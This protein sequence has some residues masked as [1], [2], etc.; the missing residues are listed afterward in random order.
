MEK[1]FGQ[2]FS[3]K[4]NEHLKRRRRL[5]VA[6]RGRT[7]NCWLAHSNA[8]TSLPL[9]F[10]TLLFEKKKT[11]LKKCRPLQQHRTQCLISLEVPAPL[12]GYFLLLL[13]DSKS[14]QGQISRW[15]PHLGLYAARRP[16]SGQGNSNGLGYVTNFTFTYRFLSNSAPQ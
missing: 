10:K 1:Y 16:L 12:L 14:W 7:K 6:K 3:N 4:S 8:T 9:T 11:K 13:W 2:N 5:E 15:G